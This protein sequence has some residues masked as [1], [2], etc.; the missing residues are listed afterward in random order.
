MANIIVSRATPYWVPEAE[1]FRIIFD[2]CVWGTTIYGGNV[3]NYYSNQ[4]AT[5]I[6]WDNTDNGYVKVNYDNNLQPG[7]TWGAVVWSTPGVKNLTMRLQT[8]AG[9]SPPFNFSVTVTAAQALV[10]N[11]QVKSVSITRKSKYVC[12]IRV[13]NC[14]QPAN[15]P[16]LVFDYTSDG[17]VSA[18]YYQYDNTT[19]SMPNFDI[20]W[21]TEGIKT[22]TCRLPLLAGGYSAPYTTTYSVYPE[23]VY[24]GISYVTSYTTFKGTS[25]NSVVYAAKANKIYLLVDSP[26]P[27][28]IDNASNFSMY[29]AEVSMPGAVLTYEGTE[30][31]WYESMGQGQPALY[32]NAVDMFSIYMPY[33]GECTF[34]ILASSL[35][36]ST[37]PKELVKR[38]GKYGEISGAYTMA[39]TDPK[40]LPLAILSIPNE[41]S[42]LTVPVGITFS[43]LATASLTVTGYSLSE[44][45]VM[46][47]SFTSSMISSYTFDSYGAKRLYLYL[48]TNKGDIAGTSA[49]VNLVHITSLITSHN[50]WYEANS[51]SYWITLQGYVT[52]TRSFGG[53]INSINS[54]GICT[55]IIF[56]DLDGGVN[57]SINK[58][59]GFA[60]FSAYWPTAGLKHLTVR[61]ETMCGPSEPYGFFVDI[62]EVRDTVPP[63]LTAFTTSGTG[64]MVTV[65]LDGYDNI[66]ITK[67][68]VHETSSRPV[69]SS[70]KPTSYTFSVPGRHTLFASCADADGNVSN[71]LCNEP[72]GITITSVDITEDANFL[73]KYY[74]RINCKIRDL[75]WVNEVSFTEASSGIVAMDYRYGTVKYLRSITYTTSGVKN[76]IIT[77]A[78]SAWQWSSAYNFSIT[79]PEIDITKPVV[80]SLT[81]PQNIRITTV[82]IDFQA[83]DNVAVTEYALSETPFYSN[84]TKTSTVPKYW[85]FSAI[86]GVKSLTAWVKD[87]QG[88]IS[89]P[90]TATTTLTLITKAVSDGFYLV[91]SHGTYSSNLT[92]LVA[93]YTAGPTPAAEVPKGIIVN[94]QGTYSADI[95]SYIVSYTS[96][97][98][99]ASE[100]A[101]YIIV[102]SQGTYRTDI[103]GCNVSYISGPAA[104]I[105]K[106][107]F[108]VVTSQGTY[109]GNITTILVDFAI[110]EKSTS[111]EIPVTRFNTDIVSP[112]YAITETL[113][114]PTIWSSTKPTTITCTTDGSKTFY[115]WVKDIDGNISMPFK[116]VCYIP[117][118]Y[119]TS[120]KNGETTAKLYTT[121]PNILI[122]VNNTKP[123]YLYLNKIP[124]GKITQMYTLTNCA[125]QLEHYDSTGSVDNTLA[126]AGRNLICI[127]V[128]TNMYLGYNAVTNTCVSAYY[129][130]LVGTT[131]YVSDPNV[132]TYADDALKD[133][134]VKYYNGVLLGTITANTLFDGNNPAVSHKLGSVVDAS[135]LVLMAVTAT[136]TDTSTIVWAAQGVTNNI[137]IVS[138]GLG[139]G[140]ATVTGGTG[141]IGGP[142]TGNTTGGKLVTIAGLPVYI[143]PIDIVESTLNTGSIVITTAG[144][145]GLV[146]Q[147]LLVNE[148]FVGIVTANT[149]NSITIKTVAGSSIRALNGIWRMETVD[150]IGR[151]PLYVATQVAVSDVAAYPIINTSSS[152]YGTAYRARVR[153]YPDG[154]NLFSVREVSQLVNA[155]T[156]RVIRHEFPTW[157]EHLHLQNGNQ[158]ALTGDATAETTSPYKAY[159]TGVW[160]N[161]LLGREVTIYK[162]AVENQDAS[163]MYT[164]NT[165]LVY[166]VTNTPNSLAQVIKRPVSYV[167][168]KIYIATSV[169]TP[170]YSGILNDTK[171][172]HILAV[173][174]LADKRYIKTT[175]EQ[176][177]GQFNETLTLAAGDVVSMPDGT[178]KVFDGTDFAAYSQTMA[179]WTEVIDKGYFDA[180]ASYSAYDLVTDR[181]TGFIYITAV[182]IIGPS[183]LSANWHRLIMSSGNA[184]PDSIFIPGTVTAS[185][186]TLD[187]LYSCAVLEV[188][189]APT[190]ISAEYSVL[191][192][193]TVT[194]GVNLYEAAVLEKLMPTSIIDNTV[195]N[196]YL[197]ETPPVMLGRQ[198]LFATQVLELA[199]PSVSYKVAFTSN[200]TPIVVTSFTVNKAS[201]TTA[202]APTTIQLKRGVKANLPASAAIGEP[203]VTTDTTEL[204]VGTGTGLRKISDVVV[205]SVEPVIEDRGK[206]WYNPTTKLTYVYK[207]SSWQSIVSQTTLDYGEF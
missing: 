202:I 112:E 109:S 124:Y 17:V 24:A 51:R 149:S 92:G 104:P 136:F 21:T 40:A 144:V 154:T 172:Y 175:P 97:P 166:S 151:I 197:P 195:V 198:G 141:G 107:K 61:F 98:I 49:A 10:G 71:E 173:T 116:A 183:T 122:G 76:L 70:I 103:S 3:N 100:V 15:Y 102:N 152:A 43:A 91:N 36:S 74:L 176:Y 90:I 106:E 1:E 56:D 193:C 129:C 204:Y 34:H 86:D 78:N 148:V 153:Y 138:K 2:A 29:T 194:S 53:A 27:Y 185:T 114:L 6:Y 94:S 88:N 168:D 79:V 146:G 22:I 60:S 66:G 105:V 206:L 69:W 201:G 62:H 133:G 64:N 174:T 186:V 177:V 188:A 120:V 163:S 41:Y 132:I 8:L 45:D 117:L 81:I 156:E 145:N 187:L 82:A 19:D 31:P 23:N 131:L 169:G 119:Y 142:V 75:D 9:I 150:S 190:N 137:S 99:P 147:R 68:S 37:F 121:D 73:G 50:I 162:G 65:N 111:L 192:Y 179:L 67:W 30:T 63:V 32:H 178:Y 108:I 46:S 4:I 5:G 20:T 16:G 161:W 89:D 11:A 42:S 157:V 18:P 59:I 203:L 115:A 55:G 127:E 126:A 96:G 160:P 140:G 200:L 39:Q 38:P 25:P 101:K 164:A 125:L 85:T 28:Y 196:L 189:A 80:N 44:S 13:D 77:A 139:T 7:T 143:K 199:A 12:R 72:A 181:N 170:V 205:S 87:R 93:T 33:A 167:K 134:T 26:R 191:A 52:G 95:S 35:M 135:G 14:S 48:R 58:T 47:T 83:S 128:T 110:P 123:N 165:K 158:Y 113:D 54:T 84:A 118:Y 159:Y 155:G 57:V 130:Y 171:Y 207:G 180:T 184:N 182:S